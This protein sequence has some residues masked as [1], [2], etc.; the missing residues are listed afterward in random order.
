MQQDVTPYHFDMTSDP[1]F[2]NFGEDSKN[3]QGPK[4]VN[5]EEEQNF[6]QI[7]S[8]EHLDLKPKVISEK[9]SVKD[10]KSAAF[11]E[12]IKQRT[13]DAR[14]FKLPAMNLSKMP[15][16][17]N[18]STDSLKT[19]ELPQNIEENHLVPRMATPKSSAN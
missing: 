13:L 1:H 15:K 10:W 6:L 11:D 4:K 9:H 5:S 17:T 8:S 14:N 7:D 12:K 16:E 19:S 3:E 2:S 18:P